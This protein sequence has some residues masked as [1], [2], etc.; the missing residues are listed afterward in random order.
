L[1]A[2]QALGQQRVGPQ[3]AAANRLEGSQS[4]NKAELD[5]AAGMPGAGETHF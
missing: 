2:L 1:L 5:A 4:A 3:A